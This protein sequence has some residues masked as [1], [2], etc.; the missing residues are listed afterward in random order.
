VSQRHLELQHFVV[1]ILEEEVVDFD[2]KL[3]RAVDWA[4]EP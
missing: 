1:K 2:D 4:G 3:A